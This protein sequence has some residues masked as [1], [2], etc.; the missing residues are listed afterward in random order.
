MSDPYAPNLGLWMFGEQPLRSD[1]RVVIHHI[2]AALNVD[3][4]NSALIVRFHLGANLA[5]V[6]LVT[7]P[8]RLFD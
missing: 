4:Y 2:S 6:D 3:G 5:L 1:K 7:P 8:G